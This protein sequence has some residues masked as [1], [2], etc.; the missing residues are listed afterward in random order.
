MADELGKSPKVIE[1]KEKAK[2]RF[3]EV[4][5]NYIKVKGK[6]IKEIS[7]ELGIP[8]GTVND[9]LNKNNK[10]LS[11]DLVSAFCAEY[12][13]V[14]LNYIYLGELGRIEKY[15]DN[16]TKIWNSTDCHPL[17]DEAFMGTYYGYCRNTQDNNKIDNFVVSI[18]ATTNNSVQA[19]LKLNTFD[20]KGTSFEK[21]LYGTPMHLEPNI[22]YIVFQSIKGDDMFILSYNYFK[23]NSGKKLYC[24]YGSLLTPC[25]A[26]NR[27]PELQP[28]LLLD[29]PVLPQNMH[30]VDGFLN[31]T[32]DKIIIPANKYD[33]ET[34]GLM[35][36]DEN[37]KTFFTKCKDMHYNKEEY[38][39]FSEKVLLALG[40]ANNVDYDTTAAA[41]MTLK[42]N[43]INP[44]VV[45][46]PNNK[47]YS[48]FFASL[49]DNS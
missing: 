26:T 9:T 22:I 47:T 43:S 31:L 41:I 49:T 40:E 20:Q 7:K 23:I 36:T 34:D 13:T 32:Q 38:Y 29:K 27:Y 30:L 6:S 25:R 42:K 10:T 17:S 8:V 5:N 21:L 48:K 11:S 4:F 16:Y 15:E 19:E 24:R 33:T 44:K 35:A 3:I 28:F 45:N 1:R 2:K 46:F 39:C 18:I 12:K 37:V 14:D